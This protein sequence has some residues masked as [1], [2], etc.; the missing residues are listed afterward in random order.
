[1]NTTKPSQDVFVARRRVHWQQLD[2]LLSQSKHLHSLPPDLI[3][4]VG[5]LYRIVCADLM[6]A[7]GAGYGQELVAYLDVLGARAHNRLYRASPYQLRKVGALLAWEFP[8]TLRESWRYMAA[9]SALFLVPFFVALAATLANPDLAAEVMP[10]QDLE[11][12]AQS[13]AE[14][15]GQ[16]RAES[17]DASM[18][19]FYVYNNV[20]ISFRVF[21]T[22]IFFGLGSMFYL[23]TNGV[24]IGATLG[25]VSAMGAGRNIL[26]FVMGHGAFELTAIVI[27]GAA[28][29]RMGYALVRTH[30]LTRLG[31]LRREGPA[32]ARLAMGAAVMLGV[33]AL[34]EGFWSPSSIADEIK[35]ATASGLWLA[36]LAYFVFAGRRRARR[37]SGQGEGSA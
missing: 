4:S 27:A 8:R 28:G 33:A 17:E 29:L 32:V 2:D 24:T 10:R 20:G 19:G 34:I 5:R 9:A 16:G 23:V 1:M 6:R 13:Y 31:S 15:F 26:T 21:A 36:V 7:R 25:Y 3:G 12:L 35:W 14:G 37:E 18:A 11:M 30:G 22:G